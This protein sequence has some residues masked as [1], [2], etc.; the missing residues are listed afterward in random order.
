[1]PFARMRES[2]GSL[3]AGTRRLPS[4]PSET[5]HH[6]ASGR[7]LGSVATAMEGITAWR[8]IWTGILGAILISEVVVVAMSEL[9]T[10][11]V[12]ADNLIIGAVTSFIASLVVLR[13]LSYLVMQ[14]R[15]S[16]E[17]LLRSQGQIAAEAKYR[18]V[19]ESMMDGFV[20][21]DMDGRLVLFNEVYRKLLGFEADELRALTYR[22]LT[23]EPWHGFEAGIVERQVLQRGYSEIYEKEYRRKDGTVFPVELR[24]TLM[25]DSAGKAV[26]MWAIVRDVTERKRAEENLRKSEARFEQLAE[27]SRS[28][29]WEVDAQGLYTYVSHV[30]EAVWGYRP[31]ELVGRMHFYDLH[32]EP[33]REAFQEAA[34][35]VF[36]RKGRFHNLEKQIRRSDGEIV[37]ASTNGTPLLNAD[38]TLRGYRGSDTDITA[39]KQAEEEKANLEAQLAQSQKM[40]SIGRLAGGVA[41]DF[42][43][44]LTVINGYSQLELAKLSA[45]DPLRT[46]IREIHTA[47]ERAAALT[48]QL[49]AFSRK[50]V[51]QPRVL[52]FNRVVREMRPM[53]ARLMGED[54]ELQVR[55]HP[56][57]ATI[58]ADPH[59][60]NQVIMNLAVN[61][62]DAMP[63]CGKLSIETAVVECGQSQTQS[64]PK[65]RV[66]RY[67]MLG[68]S[69]S[70]V[71][72][73]EETRQHI[74]EPFFTTKGVGKGTGLGLS[75][76]DG[77]VVQSGGFVEVDSEPGRGTTFRIYLPSVA[78]APA[79]GE[80]DAD[81]V[82]A[83][84]EKEIVLV[85]EDQEQVRKYAAAALG[86]FGYQVIQAD[87]ADEALRLC[88]RERERIDLVLTDVVMPLLSGR[89]LANRLAKRWPGIKV[90]FMS[91]YTDDA[92]M[93]HRVLDEGVHFIQKPFS[94]AELAGKV[95][96]VLGPPPPR[97]RPAGP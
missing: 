65:A 44:L 29:A 39:H 97:N 37:W 61:S 24:T 2:A 36:E 71:G 10:G 32:P 76:I 58:Y 63:G 22:D 68:V 92:V 35:A 48:Q 74:F 66:G 53:L 95:R 57:P 33:G 69:D 30:S 49:L 34:F 77:I 72:M 27:Q 60:L 88:E 7:L 17:E 54:V 42:N 91:G 82:F 4:S 55:L 94:P 26:G 41:H 8:L 90:L 84:G 46:S 3:P 28:I 81:P 64:H 70:G 96:A 89:E 73:D 25:R 16:R 87:G 6:G 51:L 13:L 1:M 45:E 52:D 21:V 67:V 78:D 9:L 15:I 56:E 79:V 38:G 80:P 12:P 50:Q 86:A 43:N 23:P 59:Q 14:L 62:R 47:G 19:Y 93:R 20:A 18:E 11:R 75:M 5:E 31:D 85:V 40:E 83:I